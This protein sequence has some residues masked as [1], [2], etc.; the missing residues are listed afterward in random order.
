MFEQN[1][2][3]HNGHSEVVIDV[4]VHHGEPSILG[5]LHPVWKSP[6][7]QLLSATINTCHLVGLKESKQIGNDTLVNHVID[8][9][10][11]NRI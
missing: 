8:C 9:L 3:K 6:F 2:A 10:E 5:R 7:F 1:K 4:T 11:E